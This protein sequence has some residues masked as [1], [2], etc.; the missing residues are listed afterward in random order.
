MVKI[1]TTISLGNGYID[2]NVYHSLFFFM[3]ENI[4]NKIA[5]NNIDS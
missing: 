4:Y 1:L 2:G 5:K 3:L